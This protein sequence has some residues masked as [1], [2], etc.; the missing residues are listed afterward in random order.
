MK[1]TLAA[2][3]FLSCL[4]AAR[5]EK[6][7]V[8]TRD[9]ASKNKEFRLTVGYSG[10]GGGGRARL[11]LFTAAGKKI[12]RFETDPAPFTVTISDDGHRLFLFFGSW[13]QQVTVYS[14]G[15]YDASGTKLAGHQVEM[16]GPAGED[17]SGDNSVYALGADKGSAWAILVLNAETGKL[18]WRKN[19]KERLTGLKLSGSG[20]KLLA[21][22]MPGRDKRRAVVFDKSGKELWSTEIATDNNLSPKVF[23]GDGSG[24]ELWEDKMVYDDK[25]GFW[26]DKLLKKR[27]YRFT[28]EGVEEVSAKEAKE[29]K[30]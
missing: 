19:F 27:A 11:D 24:F 6:F 30:N 4:G 28:S 14:L 10:R 16:Q 20:K 9:F 13:G 23:D 25:D 29:E 5:A 26:H 12:S 21:V 18:F 22:F 1:I 2:L 8:E 3:L 17:F 7:D 15:V